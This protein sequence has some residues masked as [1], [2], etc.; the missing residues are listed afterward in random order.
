MLNDY[1]NIS[2]FKKNIAL[3][4]LV[5]YNYLIKNEETKA[6]SLLSAYKT[7]IALYNIY[8]IYF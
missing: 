1:S 7:N 3:L 5:V 8:Y 6:I 4:L 2:Q